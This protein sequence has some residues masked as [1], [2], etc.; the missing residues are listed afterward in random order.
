MALQRYE[1]DSFCDYWNEPLPQPEPTGDVDTLIAI[2]DLLDGVEWT[3]DTLAAIA[4]L[5]VK[6]GYR[7]RDLGDV[8]RE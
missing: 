8:D 5:M 2:Q 3:P 7:I 1:T 6:A 4:V